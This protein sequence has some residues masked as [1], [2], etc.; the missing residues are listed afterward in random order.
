MLIKR[1][2]HRMPELNTASTAD[3]S[4]M[5]LIFFLVTTS[6]DVDK[7]ITRQ[8]P[9]VEQTDDKSMAEVRRDNIMQCSIG[10]DGKLTVDGKAADY[11]GLRRR[12]ASFVGKAGKRHL[13]TIHTDADACYN[14]YFELQDELVAAY[15]MVRDAEARR[16]FGKPMAQ[17][18]VAQRKTVMESCPQNVAENYDNPAPAPSAGNGPT[19]ADG[20]AGVNG[21]T[22]DG[23]G[24]GGK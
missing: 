13:I 21:S 20:P 24:G 14:S 23:K 3:I 8:L 9:P 6:M 15:S 10:A 22:D 19:D 5:L 18:T 2:R 16:R 1:R 4:F 17:C 12:I 11:K 7:G